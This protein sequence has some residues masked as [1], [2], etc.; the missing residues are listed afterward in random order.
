[1]IYL[2]DTNICIAFLHK[3]DP[4]VK[5]QLEQIPIENISLCSIVKAELLYGARHSQN[6]SRNLQTLTSFFSNFVS[7][8][9]DDKAAEHYGMIHATLRSA[10]QMIGLNDILIASIALAQDLTVVTRNTKEFIKVPGLC[11]EKW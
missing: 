9:F 10:G 4:L 6:V 5:N 2:L 1:M 7:F 8:Y 3:N 11:V